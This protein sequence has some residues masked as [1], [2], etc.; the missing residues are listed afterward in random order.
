MCIRDSPARQAWSALGGLPAVVHDFWI[1]LIQKSCTPIE[2]HPH[3]PAV[4]RG[5]ADARTCPF[6]V[7]AGCTG[8]RYSRLGYALMFFLQV[9]TLFCSLQ[10]GMDA[11]RVASGRPC[12]LPFT[13]ALSLG[14]KAPCYYLVCL[15]RGVLASFRAPGGGPGASIS[16]LCAIGGGSHLSLGWG[17]ALLVYCRHLCGLYSCIVA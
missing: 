11:Q 10:K 13:T 14:H 9:S 5:P 8:P 7:V 15:R 16:D 2:S 1:Q 4:A 3:S 6:S 17:W 12:C